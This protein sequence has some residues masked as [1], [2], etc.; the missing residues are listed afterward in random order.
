MGSFPFALISALSDDMQREVGL[1]YDELKAFPAIPPDSDHRLASAISLSRAF[2]K[3][4]LPKV[5]LD[6][7]LACWT[8]LQQVNKAAGAWTL[9]LN[10][11][12][13]EVLWGT[14]KNE[15]YK[16]FYPGGEPLVDSLDSIFLKGKVGP[17][18]SIGAANGDFYTKLFSST[19]TCTSQG[20]VDHYKSNVQRFA[21][22]SNGESIRQLH[23]SSPRIVPGSRLSFVPKNDSI[24]R[25]IC[26]EPVLN[27]YYQLGLGQ[28]IEERLRSYFTI[29]LSLQPSLNAELARTGSVDGSW[30]TIDLESASDSISMRF[31]SEVLPRD[32]FSYFALLRSRETSYKGTVLTLNMVSTMGNGFTFPLQ[33]AIF[34]AAVRSVYISLGLKEKA[35]VFGDDIVVLST[36]YNRLIRL[37]T[38]CGFT[39]NLTKSFSEGPF[40]ESCGFDYFLGRNIRGVYMKSFGTLQDSYALI[41]ALNLFSA[42]TGLV[43]SSLMSWLLKRVDRSIEI[44]PWENP[45]GGIMLP[46]SMI[47]SRRVSETTQGTLYTIYEFK[48]R[49]LRV[50]QNMRL[51]NGRTV[52]YNCSGLLI[53]FL[54]GVALSSGLP[55]RKEGSWK[56]K[57]RSCSYWNS[58]GPDPRVLR[59]FGWQQWESAV[60]ANVS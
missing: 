38:I 53:A 59:G 55:L 21:E 31:L 3:K 50:S 45:S 8:K 14:L 48:A 12:L 57:L 6:Q 32:V 25:S 43:V 1:S 22:W 37:L 42:R 18:A 47:K 9:S 34:A 16:F 60:Y 4:F 52:I 49:R 27:M 36:V 10:T 17:G 46:Y 5:T 13:D 23:Y 35:H 58:F 40:R 28:I 39:V 15:L 2:T 29:D 11:S 7:D 56:K 33:T 20:L 19:L 44:P 26:T 54:A 41:N 30:S 24:S 51:P